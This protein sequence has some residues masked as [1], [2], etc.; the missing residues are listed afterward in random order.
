MAKRMQKRL[1]DYAGS[2]HALIKFNGDYRWIEKDGIMR[3]TPEEIDLVQT[4]RQAK[5][6]AKI[7]SKAE[8][9]RQKA[10]PS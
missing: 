9:R 3:L 10:L 4:H 6:Q 5:K 1:E 7:D 8:K 2:R